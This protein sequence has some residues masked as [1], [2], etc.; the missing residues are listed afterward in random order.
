MKTNTASCFP[1]AGFSPAC[2]SEVQGTG[3]ALADGSS[4]SP[5]CYHVWFVAF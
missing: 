3:W 1:W 2:F 4:G 5:D